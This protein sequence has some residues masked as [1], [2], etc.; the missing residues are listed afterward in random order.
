MRFL[1]LAVTAAE[2]KQPQRKVLFDTA[3]TNLDVHLVGQIGL[4]DNGFFYIG[5]GCAC[6]RLVPSI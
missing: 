1:G 2:P 4:G 3:A 6:Q 5:Q